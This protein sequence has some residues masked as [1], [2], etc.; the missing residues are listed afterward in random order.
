MSQASITSLPTGIGYLDNIGYQLTWTGTPTG[1]FIVYVSQDKVNWTILNTSGV[2]NPS[3]SAGSTVVQF[4][5][6]PFW[7][8]E[9]QYLKTSGTGT[10]NAFVTGKSF[11]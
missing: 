6:L 3:G 5:N 9:I 11:A 7:W 8:I 4:S 10:L 2:T 1:T